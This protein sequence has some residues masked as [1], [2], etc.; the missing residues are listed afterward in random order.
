MSEH[1]TVVK[2]TAAT[3]VKGHEDLTRRGRLI[4]ALLNDEGRIKTKETGFSWTYNLKVRERGLR[5]LASGTRPEFVAHD[6]DEQ[7]TFDSRGYYKSDFVSDKDKSMNSGPQAIVDR[8]NDILPDLLSEMDNHLPAEFLADGIADTSRFLGLESFFGTTGSTVAAD[9][10]AQP[11]VSSYAGKPTTLGGLGGTWGATMSTYPNANLAKDWPFGSGSTDYDANSPKILNTTSTSW[12]GTATWKANC[13]V[14]M[15]HAMMWCNRLNGDDRGL[16]LHLL[17]DD[18]FQDFKDHYRLKN[19]RLEPNE[20]AAELGFNGVLNFE[21]AMIK[22]D[23]DVA[24]GVGYGVNFNAMELFS[25]KD[26]LLFSQGPE[27]SMDRQGYMF[28][29]GIYGNIKCLPKFFA[30]Y[31][32]IA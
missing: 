28:L 10:I 6:S 19:V 15:S 21:G 20:R 16:F 24:T 18:L 12:T 30:K 2:Q 32:A 13:E 29:V 22:S 5:P 3:Y 11:G 7:L 14:V 4:M 26:Q 27:F 8:Y 23:F 1:M 9:K 31:K 25:I 17:S